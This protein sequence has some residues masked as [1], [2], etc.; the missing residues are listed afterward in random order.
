MPATAENGAKTGKGK[1]RSRRPAA[2]KQPVAAA[3]PQDP[4]PLASD[5]EIESA[6]GDDLAIGSFS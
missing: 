6:C 4:S 2:A 5:E 1:G 3:P